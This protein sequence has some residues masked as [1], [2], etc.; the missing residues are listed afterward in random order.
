MNHKSYRSEVREGYGVGFWKEIRKEGPLMFKNDSF[1]EGDG[2]RVKFW[3]DIWCGNIPLCEAFPSLF[4]F[5]ASQDAWVADCWD[6]MG[7]VGGWSPCFSRPFNDWE[8]EAVVSLLS[9]LQGKQL[10]VGLEDR[11]LWN[12]SKNGIFSVKSLYNTLDSSGAVP[13]PWK[14]IWSPCVPTKVG[15]FCLGNFLGEGSNPRSTQ[16]EGFELS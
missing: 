14:I 5:A 2:K 4:P 11:V 1:A 15:F 3:K 12:A 13:F 6:S 10:F 8:M 7:D 16:E 9:I